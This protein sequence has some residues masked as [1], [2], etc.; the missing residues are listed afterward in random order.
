VPIRVLVVDD[1]PLFR[2]ALVEALSWSD[3]IDVVGV[4]D[5]GIAACGSADELQPDVVVMDVSMPDLSGIDAMQRIH[6]RRPGLPVVF[7]TARGDAGVRREAI[8]AGGTGYVTKGAP[9]DDIVRAIAD[10]AGV[11]LGS[12]GPAEV[13]V[14]FAL[15]DGPQAPAELDQQLL[16]QLRMLVEEGVEVP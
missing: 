8:A 12:A 3:G 15:L 16:G 2:E 9:L 13:S 1:H 5:G 14:G 7:L 10:A 4:A 11:D 6:R